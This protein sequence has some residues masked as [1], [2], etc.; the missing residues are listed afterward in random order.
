MK[1]KNILKCISC[2]NSNYSSTFKVTRKDK[3]ASSKK[4]Q[5]NPAQYYECSVC[6][7]LIL[8]D[9]SDYEEN[10][11]D[12]G[13]YE[14]E[15]KENT[16]KFIENRFNYVSNLE[17]GFSDNK[18][19]IDRVLGFIESKFTNQINIMDIGAG[20][21]IFFHEL[22]NKIKFKGV[23]LELD[24]YCEIHLKNIFK[25]SP[26]I[27]TNKTVD[28]Y[29]TRIKFDLITINRVLEHIFNPIDF[30]ISVKKL[31]SDLGFVYV[32]VPDTF[33]Y[34]KDGKN[35]EAFGYGHYYIFNPKALVSIFKKSGFKLIQ[36]ERCV[37][38]SGK[39]TLYAFF[40]K[41]N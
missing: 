22:L 20:M 13:Y 40:K 16:L 8:D 15:N 27:V 28:K 26:V 34:Y 36:F 18:D 35:N 21:G 17:R 39:Y 23:A 7:L 1:P 19:R 37:E 25:N 14:S 30:L 12:G 38:P 2:Q 9:T 29:E 24:P 33:S 3:F 5:I 41:A 32:E 4:R 11:S 31:I 10:Y 6:K